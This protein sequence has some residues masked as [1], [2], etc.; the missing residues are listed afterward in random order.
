MKGKTVGR[1]PTS[2]RSPRGNGAGAKV[3]APAPGPRFPVTSAIRHGLSRRFCPHKHAVMVFAPAA[4]ENRCLASLGNPQEYGQ[5]TLNLYHRIGV[6][7]SEGLPH[8]AA[9]HSHSLVHHHL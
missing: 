4:P 7:A 3:L 1:C 2:P 5:A 9:L 8:L 6:N